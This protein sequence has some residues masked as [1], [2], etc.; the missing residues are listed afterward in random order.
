MLIGYAR[1]STLDQNP[2]FQNDALKKA[3]CEKIFTDTVSGTVP[4]KPFGSFSQRPHRLDEL[5]G[6]RG[7]RFE[8]FAGVY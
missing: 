8:K 5:F 2:D 1:V 3:G 4:L 7:G 6:Y